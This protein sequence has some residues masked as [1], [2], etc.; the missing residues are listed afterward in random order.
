[1]GKY[2]GAALFAEPPVLIDTPEIS[3]FETT[4]IV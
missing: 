4:E 3:G 1:V 2:E